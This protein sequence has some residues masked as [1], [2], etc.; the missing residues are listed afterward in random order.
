MPNQSFFVTTVVHHPCPW[1]VVDSL[2]FCLV[3]FVSSMNL[4]VA[5]NEPDTIVAHI[6]QPA[7]PLIHPSSTNHTWMDT[8][9]AFPELM[10][11][12]SDT[13]LMC[14]LSQEWLS[15]PN[16]P[17][18]SHS[19]EQFHFLTLTK[20][21]HLAR[22][23]C[24]IPSN[25][26]QRLGENCCD[27][28]RDVLILF[29]WTTST[30]R[31]SNNK[32]QEIRIWGQ[33]LSQLE[34]T[35][36][37]AGRKHRRTSRQHFSASHF[38][39]VENWSS[40]STTLALDFHFESRS[41]HLTASSHAQPRTDLD[42]ITLFAGPLQP[43]L[44]VSLEAKAVKFLKSVTP[45]F[46]GETDAFLGSFGRTAD[47][48]STDFVQ[49]IMV[50]LSTPNQTIIIATM[51]MLG[52]L[53]NL[54]SAKIRLAF[55]KADLITQLINSLNPQSLSLSDCEDIHINLMKI[56]N[57]CIWLATPYGLEQF[58]IEDRD[59]R[60]AVYE[61]VFSQVLAPSEKFFLM[62]LAQIL[63]ISQYYQP[64]LDFV[65]HMPFR[66][67]VA[68]LFL[69]RRHSSIV[70]GNESLLFM[71]VDFRHFI[72]LMLSLSTH[73]LP[74]PSASPSPP[75]P[76]HSPLPLPHH[77]HP[78]T[79]SASPHHTPSHSLCL[80]L[81]THTSHSPLPLPHHPHPH[82]LLCLSS[83]PTPSHSPLPLLTTHTLPLPL[84]LP[85]HP[86]PHSPL[87]L[88]HHPTLPFPLPLPHHPPTPLCLSLTTH[89][90]TSL[91]L[92]LT[93]HTLPLPLPLPH[94]PHP[95]TP[96]CLS[97]TTH[98]LPLPLPLPHHPHPPIPSASPSPPTPSTPL[99]LSLTT[100]TLTLPLPLPHHPHPPTPSASPSPPTPSH[101]LSLPSPPTPSTPS[102]SP[103]PP[104]PS[105]SPLPLPHHPHPPTPL[106]LSLTSL[107]VT[108]ANGC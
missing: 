30:T 34:R 108:R 49:C 79:P 98:T 101:S 35:E 31:S 45:Y 23:K 87:P 53:I 85:H 11:L 20:S 84:P 63:E 107:G 59:E 24:L 66:S 99:C 95:P 60:R 7:D 77:P 71:L 90:L 46:E 82:T 38:R 9:Y 57:C 62:L 55:F 93:T 78:P 64:T 25:S 76:S 89:T 19:Q 42:S 74:L 36:R 3:R 86:H 2:P 106:C 26:L 65:L 67:M 105:H 69:L 94:H 14:V 83:P 27:D 22:P 68:K 6:V 47:L 16:C 81:T 50:L 56:I 5:W 13:I 41:S 88:P 51:E 97:L 1:S 61:T 43:A 80:S 44:D 54:C 91:S 33:L 10:I 58:E 73:T 52:T 103:S 102:A 12:P 17:S 100:H 96:L 8:R 15:F 39:F 4:R 32:K 29:D 40:P 92:S 70:N 18:V 48:S 37:L 75:S 28:G 104:T 21:S 72:T